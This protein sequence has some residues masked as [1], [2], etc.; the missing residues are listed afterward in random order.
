MPGGSEYKDIATFAAAVFALM[1]SNQIS[2]SVMFLF[3]I[4]V[5]QV[6]EKWKT[7][8]LC[9]FGALGSSCLLY[10][11]WNQILIFFTIWGTLAFVFYNAIMHA[12]DRRAQ[13][14]R[15]RTRL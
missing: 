13:N 11:P 6:E 9:V 10:F 5:K 12:E 8:F 14:A 7:A 2:A 3:C 15:R 4:L 1:K